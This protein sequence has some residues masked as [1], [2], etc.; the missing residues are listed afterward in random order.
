MVQCGEEKNT[1]NRKTDT[2][3]CGRP[4]K[5][6]NRK[7]QY[8]YGIPAGMHGTAEVGGEDVRT[9]RRVL[10]LVSADTGELIRVREH[11]FRCFRNMIGGIIDSE[12]TETVGKYLGNG[13]RLVTYGMS[14]TQG[15]EQKYVLYDGKNIRA[16]VSQWITC[17]FTDCFIVSE[18]SFGTADGNRLP[19]R[20]FWLSDAEVISV[21]AYVSLRSGHSV[22]ENSFCDIGQFGTE[23]EAADAVSAFAAE[24]FR[25]YITARCS[26][27][28]SGCGNDAMFAVAG[29]TA[30][31]AYRL[32]KTK[33]GQSKTRRA[34]FAG[35]A[36]SR[37]SYTYCGLGEKYE[38]E[39]R[40]LAFSACISDGG[41][42][43]NVGLASYEYCT[44]HPK[45]SD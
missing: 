24:F 41:R 16:V 26:A 7:R 43:R 3:F 25:P 13:Y 39:H 18:Y 34:D 5:G 40:T 31:A 28:E 21:R 42:T 36:V 8:R 37:S 14:G 29:R 17:E 32:L 23:E 27:R 1:E 22:Y 11:A 33:K 38:T 19:R 4:Q 6:K 10:C 15:E 35:V 20:G 44:E 12:I 45:A 30:D 9:G 2:V